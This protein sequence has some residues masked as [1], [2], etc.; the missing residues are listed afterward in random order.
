MQVAKEEFDATVVGF[1]G[2]NG[3]AF[4]Q[5]ADVCLTVP[6][7]STPQVESFHL[8]LEHL[9]TF[10]LKEKIANCQ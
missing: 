2:F 3:G 7:A 1:S 10:C 8:A 9:I 4:R 6:F 5:V